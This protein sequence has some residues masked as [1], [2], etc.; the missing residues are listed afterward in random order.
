MPR[1]MIIEM[2]KNI[3]HALRDAARAKDAAQATKTD[4]D[5]LCLDD[6]K[7][8]SATKWVRSRNQKVDAIVISDFTPGVSAG[9][10][11]DLIKGLRKDGVDIPI[12]ATSS[13]ENLKATYED[14]GATAFV[15]RTV[16][17]N[18]AGG[19]YKALELLDEKLK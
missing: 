7:D 6:F 9:W 13:N 10:V 19:L 17:S 1:V 16:D 2:D 12:V 3:C 18:A 14:A 5:F 4:L 11:T 8:K 15:H